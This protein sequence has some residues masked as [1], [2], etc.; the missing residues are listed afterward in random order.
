MTDLK[1]LNGTRQSK[2]V[3]GAMQFGGRANAADARAMFDACRAADVNHFDTANGYTE[4]ASETLL[5]EMVRPERDDLIL[6]TKVG[7][8]GRADR[9]TLTAQFD[10]SRKRLGLDQVDLLYLHRFDPITDLRETIETF[11]DFRQAGLIRY[12]GLSNFAAW[13]VM[14]AITIA[15]K[16]G[17]TIDVLQPMYNL[18]KRQAE[19]EILPMCMDQSVAI[20]PY[21]PLGGGLLTGKYARGEPG[22]LTEDSRYAARYAPSWMTQAAEGLVTIAER[23]GIAP[24]TL[25]VA[26]VAAHPSAPH[27]IISARNATQLAPSLAAQDYRLSETLYAELSTLSPTPPPATDRIE[28]QA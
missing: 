6:A 26:W 10:L 2:L 15:T 8:T 5:G 25:A 21:S 4:G 11:A 23:E 19:V 27:P 18:V 16:M 22:R 28:E 12:V 14:K 1:S 9:A 13:Q 24:A 3:F 7:Y 17:L 20:L